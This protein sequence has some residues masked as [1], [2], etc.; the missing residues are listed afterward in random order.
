VFSRPVDALYPIKTYY[1]EKGRRYQWSIDE[2]TGLWR[3]AQRPDGFGQHRGTDFACPSG[4]IVW[5]MADGMVIRARFE[6][7][8][9]YN[10]G[11]GLYILQLVVMPGFDSHVLRY[12]HLKAVHVE[13]GQRIYRH[14]PIAESGNSGAADGEYLHVDLMDLKYRW[15]AIPLDG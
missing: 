2:D 7:P 10:V 14:T 15:L 6:N 13:V 12:T 4:T 9:D 8:L 11:A 5:A 3:P 1:G